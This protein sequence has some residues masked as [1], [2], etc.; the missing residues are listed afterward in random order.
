MSDS[1]SSAAGA[2][3][4]DVPTDVPVTRLA[5]AG[6][7]VPRLG[8]GCNN[9]GHNPF[10]TVI[11]YEQSKRVIHAAI[12]QGVGSFDTADVYG[13][14]ESE[15]YL[16][17]ALKGRDR[18]EL[19][20]A[21]KFGYEMPDAPEVPHGSPG[22]VRWAVESS[23]RRLQVDYI[24]LIALHRADP[25]TPIAET[26]AAL[27]ELTAEGK[28]R[29]IG[30]SMFTSEQLREAVT[31]AERESLPRIASCMMHYSL[32]ERS[33]EAG[34]VATCIDL[35]ITV[36]PF[37]PLEGGLLTGKYRR[38][39]PNEGDGRH[40]DASEVT[41]ETWERL[42]ELERVA[43][44]L[45]VSLLELS[46]GGLLS[47]PGVSALF[48]GATTPAQVIANARAVRWVPSPEDM[49]SLEDVTGRSQGESS[50]LIHSWL[51]GPT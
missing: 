13:D 3:C 20:I 5:E 11:G 18:G 50:A 51:S 40:R 42:G 12:D 23:L 15:E 1:A 27:D 31:V 39:R 7:A 4:T 8:L 14:G 26:L 37:F 28:I 22:Y 32:L 49:A 2:A 17:R 46:L 34:P 29:W 45:G 41:P 25:L 38:D 19:F 16:G 6:L 44:A 48:V 9:F 33:N 43:D 30:C 36:L 24:D 21:T 35:G 10:G 47:M